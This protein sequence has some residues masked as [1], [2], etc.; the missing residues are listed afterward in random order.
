M[1]HLALSIASFIF[2]A[3]C[4]IAVVALVIY[5]LAIVGPFLLA[6]A[7]VV[8]AGALVYLY[9]E[10][11]IGWLGAAAGLGVCYLVAVAWGDA[12]ESDAFLALGWLQMTAVAFTIAGAFFVLVF[13]NQ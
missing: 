13:V 10:A 12:L 5:V 11:A 8:G 6:L 3:F 9:P 1:I 7:A 2:L 4:A